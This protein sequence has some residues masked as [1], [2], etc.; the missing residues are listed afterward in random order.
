MPGIADEIDGAMQ[1]APQPGRQFMT[2]FPGRCG[3]GR[4][5]RNVE[6]L[7]PARLRVPLSDSRFPIP[8]TN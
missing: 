8:E 7:N 2:G 6:I 1:Q 3:E 4:S 5:V